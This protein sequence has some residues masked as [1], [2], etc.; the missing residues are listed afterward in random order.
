MEAWRR[1]VGSRHTTRSHDHPVL[2]T[3]NGLLHENVRTCNTHDHLLMVQACQLLKDELVCNPKNSHS[4]DVVNSLASLHKVTAQ[5]AYPSS[6][7][8]EVLLS[9]RTDLHDVMRF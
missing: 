9:Q 8:V 7:P 4:T 1:H 5:S 2:G 6:C 3:D